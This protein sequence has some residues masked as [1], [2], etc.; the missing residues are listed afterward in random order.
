MALSH[1]YPVQPF[2]LC[3]APG[4]LTGMHCICSSWEDGQ[5]MFKDA[6]I[7]QHNEMLNALLALS[8]AQPN[9]QACAAL[10]AYSVCNRSKRCL[11][12]ISAAKA[13]PQPD[14]SQSIQAASLLCCE[15]LIFA[16]VFQI[17]SLGLPL[18]QQG[19]SNTFTKAPY[20]QQ[21]CPAALPSRHP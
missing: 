15:K 21:V 7:L 19:C 9:L 14:G 4:F 6:L 18:L 17:L 12:F 3:C 1:P 10:I 2:W 11:A 5:N 20:K 13:W 16:T 8:S